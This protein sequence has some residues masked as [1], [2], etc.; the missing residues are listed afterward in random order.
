M[1]CP[2][3]Q[4]ICQLPITPLPL[5]Y[6]STT[7]QHPPPT[8]QPRTEKKSNNFNPQ[9]MTVK[10]GHS[11]DLHAGVSKYKPDHSVRELIPL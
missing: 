7:R 1:H 8:P 9:S 5:L 2:P 4:H 11:S 6:P 10:D 3:P